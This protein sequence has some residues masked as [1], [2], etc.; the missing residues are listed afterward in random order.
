MSTFAFQAPETAAAN[1]DFAA[2]EQRVL[3]TVELLKSERLARAAAEAKVAELH[4][5]LEAQ[6]AE[7][8]RVEAEVDAFKS[9]RE[10]VRGRIERLLGQLDELS[11]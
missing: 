10:L 2:L 6:T 9:E 8:L 4:Q 5:S 1:D 11:S 3:R 7:L